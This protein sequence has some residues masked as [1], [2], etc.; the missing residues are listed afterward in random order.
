VQSVNAMQHRIKTNFPAFYRSGLDRQVIADWIFKKNSAPDSPEEAAHQKVWEE[1]L[2]K[3][4]SERRIKSSN[5]L[6]WGL[7]REHPRFFEQGLRKKFVIDW[8]QKQGAYRPVTLYDN[9]LKRLYYDTDNMRGR[10]VINPKVEEYRR[11]S[12]QAYGDLSR[13]YVQEWLN[14]QEV[15]GVFTAGPALANQRSIQRIVTK[16]PF[17][18]MC[19]DLVDMATKESDGQKWLLN[20]IDTFSKRAWSKAMPDK[21]ATTVV[22]YLGD[23]LAE[24]RDEYNVQP[25]MIQSD[26]GSEFVSKEMKEF[27][28]QKGIRQ[29]FS[30]PRKPQ[31]NGAI[32]RFNGTLERALN[33][34]RYQTGNT[35]WPQYLDKVMKNYNSN[36]HNTIK[37]TPNDVV[38]KWLE[39]GE[40]NDTYEQLQKQRDVMN[41]TISRT[42]AKLYN[43]GQKVRIRLEMEKRSGR[44]WSR[45]HFTIISR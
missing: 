17:T 2:G 42:D 6:F 29:I 24:M 13:R 14:R 40:S 45:D 15:H 18:R 5:R 37:S 3:L 7:M 38:K 12:P 4:Y 32:E 1:E 11:Y 36:Y 19:M 44:N 33:Q 9:L 41:P 34:V 25:R 26:N 30:L 23:I 35:H 21:E 20:I 10:D 31:S 8:R 39:S 28:E 43:V 22:E 16:K 27:L